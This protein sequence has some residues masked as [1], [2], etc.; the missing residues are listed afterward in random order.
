LAH[1]G[2]SEQF[3]NRHLAFWFMSVD[4]TRAIIAFFF[5]LARFMPCL[6]PYFCSSGMAGFSRDAEAASA[7][8]YLIFHFHFDDVS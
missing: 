6:E 5:G 4:G 1:F 3:D 2:L 8:H 7:D